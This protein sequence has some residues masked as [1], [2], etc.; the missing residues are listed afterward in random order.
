MKENA[1]MK[2]VECVS[3]SEKE[4]ESKDA[5]KDKAKEAEVTEI[6]SFTFE[7]QLKADKPQQGKKQGRS[8]AAVAFLKSTGSVTDSLPLPTQL[9]LCQ[10]NPASPFETILAYVRHCFLPFSRTALMSASE[11]KID[12]SS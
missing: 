1:W 3:C 9:H 5:A 10:L 12:D 6:E 2:C 4:K 11:E 8:S 7:L